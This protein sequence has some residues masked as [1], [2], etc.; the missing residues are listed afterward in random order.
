MKK[1]DFP[2]QQNRIKSFLNVS[3]K[4]WD[5][6]LLCNG[7]FSMINMPVP[8]PDSSP[9]FIYYQAFV[10]AMN[11]DPAP[12][13]AAE[14]IATRILSALER[15]ATRTE[16]SSAHL[17]RLFVSHGLRAPQNAFPESFQNYV[18]TYMTTLKRNPSLSLSQHHDIIELH[19]MWQMQARQAYMNNNSASA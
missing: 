1:S 15:A 18:E 14:D 2:N 12:D 8:L 4:E 13:A 16:T 9:D 19:N 7:S 6:I 17:A 10:S 11:A 3:H 5:Y